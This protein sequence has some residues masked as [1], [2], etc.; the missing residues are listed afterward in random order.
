V[1]ALLS[2]AALVAVLAL[3]LAAVPALA[4]PGGANPSQICADNTFTVEFA[5][6][7]SFPQEIA[8]HGGCVSTV[9]RYGNPVGP[10]EY[11]HSA[12]VAQC[13][14]LQDELPPELWNAPVE[15]VE[16]EGEVPMNVGGFGGKIS[17]CTYLL[18]G[19]HSGTL[20]HPE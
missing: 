3:L 18:K 19:Y 4:A 11:S 5:P 20:T 1:K 16:Q 17:T 2:K 6:G 8:S 7:V 12:Y 9:A 10:G 15:I 14:V 13:K